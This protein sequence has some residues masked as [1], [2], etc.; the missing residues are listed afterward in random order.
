L[1]GKAKSV[2]FSSAMIGV[3]SENYY[4]HRVKRC[5]IESVKDIISCWENGFSFSF[6]FLE[7]GFNLGEVGLL[8]F[9]GEDGFSRRGYLDGVDVYGH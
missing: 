5:R 7:K 6:F 2:S 8:K 9:F 3:L 4:F 1:Y